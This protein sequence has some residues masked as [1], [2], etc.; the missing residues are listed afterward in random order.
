[1][2]LALDENLAWGLDGMSKLNL[3]ILNLGGGN[4]ASV[5]NA[6]D[7]KYCRCTELL[8]ARVPSTIDV[9]VIP[10]VGDAQ[11]ISAALRDKNADDVWNFVDS[12]KKII[13]ICLGMQI[14]FEYTHETNPPSKGMELF[15]GRTDRLSSRS[16]HI[17]WNSVKFT[18]ERFQKYD[19]NHFYF[20]HGYRIY[21]KFDDIVVGFSYASHYELLP[22]VVTRGQIFGFQ[23]HPEKSQLVG[24]S[25]LTDTIFEF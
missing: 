14:L 17:G 1:M 5:S 24:K 20:N 7:K 4:I 2:V 19:N 22:S 18:D 10:G 11:K 6:V 25:L 8:D 16:F 9:L 12:G 15:E 13:G 21:P 3:G 23:F